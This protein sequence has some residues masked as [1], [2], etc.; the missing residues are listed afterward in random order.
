MVLQSLLFYA[1]LWF[2]RGGLRRVFTQFI[3][4]R[5]ILEKKWQLMWQNLVNCIIFEP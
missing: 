1:F 2:K 5:V 3:L 4:G